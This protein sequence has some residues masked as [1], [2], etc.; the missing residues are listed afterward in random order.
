MLGEDLGK[1]K[2]PELGLAWTPAQ[3][4]CQRSIPPP[5]QV[6]ALRTQRSIQEDVSR[7]E[8]PVH[9]GAPLAPVADKQGRC[10]LQ[11]HFFH[12]GFVHVVPAIAAGPVSRLPRVAAFTRDW[13]A[14]ACCAAAP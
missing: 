12:K 10:H 7:L 4:Q 14:R 1:A 8:I 3:R 5:Q 6:T 13:G 11:Q 9:D 2:V